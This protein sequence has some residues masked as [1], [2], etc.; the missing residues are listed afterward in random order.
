MNHK[1]L[2]GGFST[3][4][5]SR[6]R[7]RPWDEQSFTIQAGVRHAP[8]HPQAPQMVKVERNR[9]IFAPGRE[10]AYRRLAVR[11]AARIQI[12]PDDSVFVSNKVTDGHKIVGNAVPVNLAHAL[13]EVVVK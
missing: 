13:A 9:R 5:I 3:V 7:V 6:N 8:P 1:F 2:T 10:D 11:E 4:Y 12:F